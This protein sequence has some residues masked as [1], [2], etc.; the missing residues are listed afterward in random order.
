MGGPR[1]FSILFNYG[2]I[3]NSRKNIVLLG[4]VGSGKTT[5]MN[6]LT[7]AD[8]QTGRDCT[9]VTSD[10]Q[11]CSSL[12][13]SSIIF[14]FPGF[15]VLDDIIPVFKVQYKTLRNIP[16][17]GICFVV[18]RRDRPELIVDSLIGL[19]ETFEDY[20]K[21]IIIII[22]K[23]D[24]MD[25]NKK[26]ETK[27]YILEKTRFDKII[28]SDINKDGH[29]ILNYINSFTQN[30]EVLSEVTPK[31]REFLRYFKK[32]TDDRMK[33]FKKEFIE[34]FEDTIE[35][36]KEK[37]DQPSTDKALKRALFFA[38]KDYKNNLIERY[39][40]VAKREQDYSEYVLE[41]VLAFS[42]QIFH[43]FDK[44]RVKAEKEMDICLTNYKGE[45]NKFK[46]CPHCGTIWFKISGCDG[47]TQC[48]ERNSAKDKFYGIY[49]DYSVKYENKQLDITMSNINQN[50]I[51][52][53]NGIS[54][55]TQAEAQANNNRSIQGLH[56]I[57]P[58][59]CGNYIVW[60]EM[61][62]V[63]DKVN[64]IL[65]NIPNNDYDIKF[66][67]I[68]KK[69]ESKKFENEIHELESIK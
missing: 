31:S 57:Q 54:G 13:Y 66:K 61:E 12:D 51:I 39:Y 4:E 64:E 18:E 41:H 24:E 1:H 20:C 2:E 16:I 68:L 15:K 45:V 27:N 17:R 36:F 67:E 56:K 62:D 29:V 32:T 46:R 52:S 11:I 3:K 58:V 47:K 60:R 50:E 26:E 65:K 28:F 59:G 21:N 43:D 9:S 38:L 42:N 63:T 40:D 7:G 48:G 23:T 33:Q 19:K 10:V 14:D 5:L 37:F 8:F 55:L 34:E 25:D 49:K 44:F 35:I 22:T 6:K 69:E 53:G 30:M